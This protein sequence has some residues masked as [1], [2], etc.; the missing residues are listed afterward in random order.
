MNRNP[1]RKVEHDEFGYTITF[2]GKVGSNWEQMEAFLEK[3][4]K[5]DPHLKWDA[6]G[7]EGTADFKVVVIRKNCSPRWCDCAECEDDDEE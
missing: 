3:L 2:Y 6:F 7:E 4:F 5:G 1:F